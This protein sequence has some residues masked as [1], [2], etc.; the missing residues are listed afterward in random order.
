MISTT[1]RYFLQV[2]NMGSVTMAS[3]A[4]HVAPSAVSR[5]IHSL[6][7]EH[8]VPL[9]ERTARGMTLTEAG[10]LLAVYVRRMQL[11]SE[12]LSAEMRALTDIG[13]SVIRIAANEGFGREFLPHVMGEFMKRE[14]NVR[15][16]LQ[17]A[18]RSEVSKKVKRGEVDIGMAYSLAPVDGVN[19]AY[20]IRAP[21]HAVMSPRHPLAKRERLSLHDIAPYAVVISTP[22]SS[23]RALVD[24]C[25]LHAK[26]E[27]N[28]VLISDYSG[29]LQH[30]IRDY[31]AITLAGSLTVM[32]AIERGDVV[33]IPLD[34]EDLYDRSVQIHTMQGRQL[35]S[36]VERFLALAIDM[37]TP[38]TEGDVS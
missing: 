27:L 10:E 22:A 28:Y 2:A 7:S 8:G 33:A 20:S 26:I 29:A 24:Y 23:T 17:V 12:K 4:L 32:H 13:K 38:P 21:L 1:L 3:E 30:F 11:E 19:V 9:F 18:I 5:R 34:N 35:P 36:S 15:F 14:P 6:E 16:E 31:E 37:A 25:C